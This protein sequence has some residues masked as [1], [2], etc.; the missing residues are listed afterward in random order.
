MC[1]HPDGKGH[2]TTILSVVGALQ[3]LSGAAGNQA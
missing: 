2:V 3:N 1:D